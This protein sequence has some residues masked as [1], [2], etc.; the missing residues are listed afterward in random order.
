MF[1]QIVEDGVC[2]IYCNIH[3]DTVVFL[4]L[5]F[6]Y[7]IWS[8]SCMDKQ[9]NTGQR[10]SRTSGVTSVFLVGYVLLLGLVLLVYA[11]FRFCLCL[12]GEGVFVFVLCLLCPVFPVSLY[13]PFVIFPFGFLERYALY[14]MASY[15]S[16]KWS[17]LQIFKQPFNH[18]LR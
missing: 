9:R 11:V 3:H 7:D 17:M 6:F 13:C 15:F 12:L 8:V 1:W 4:F 16:N 5:F 14:L 10:K 18:Y 2:I